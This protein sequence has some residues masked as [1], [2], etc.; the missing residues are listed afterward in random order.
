MSRIRLRSGREFDFLNPDSTRLTL[1][2]IAQGL[3]WEFRYSNQTY[4]PMTVA[5]HSVMACDH[6][7]VPNEY[8]LGMLFHDASEAVM[9]DISAPLKAL[10]P[11]YREIEER[12]QESILRNLAI[13]PAPKELIKQ[14][15][16]QLRIWEDRNLWN[17]HPCDQTV[18][19]MD[20]AHDAFM[21]RY[22]EVGR[23]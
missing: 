11:D 6:P 22:Y 21:R 1:Y 19:S 12:V 3:A 4:L 10:L 5:Q 20:K 8:R 15:D 7:L 14:V 9:R 16:E 2:D 17:N 18:W 23:Y 13:N